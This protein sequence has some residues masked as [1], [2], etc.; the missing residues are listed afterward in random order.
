MP[1]AKASIRFC[2]SRDGTRIAYAVAG[3]GPTLVKAANLASHIET[4]VDH[5]VVGGLIAA[6][7]RGRRLVRYDQRG[8]GLSDWDVDDFSLPRQLEDLEAVV[9]A[10]GAPR[11]SLAGIA[12][13]SVMALRHA[14]AHAGRVQRLVLYGAFVVGRSARSHSTEEQAEV[15]TLLKLVELGWGKDESSF[16]QLYTSQ[17]VPGGSAEQFHALNELLRRAST[18]RNAARLLREM[19]K[20]DQTA[21]AA[22]VVCPA[23]VVHA[24]GDQRV[25]FAQ[26]RALAAAL[27]NAR[28]VSLESVN[29]LLLPGE[30][31]LAAFEAELDAFLPPSLEARGAAPTL[32]S[33]PLTAREREVLEYLAR[34]LDNAQIGAHVGISEKTVR[35]YVSTL[36]DKLDVRTRAEAIVKARE[37]GLGVAPAG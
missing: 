17:F 3:D 11:Y 33:D 27:P 34:G 13:G 4:E 19:H 36:F 26:G 12:G 15:E 6:L 7:G 29:H 25:P 5:P 20:T 14:A 1:Q 18:P 22:A 35:N 16:R 37:A 24:R 32:S 21:A 28:F 31:A 9:D 10:V 23:L 2:G 8:F 30:S